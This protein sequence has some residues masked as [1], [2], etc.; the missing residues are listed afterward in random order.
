MI[1]NTIKL[2]QISDCHLFSN[3]NKSHKKI[4]PYQTLKKLLSYIQQHESNANAI[5]LTGD[6][7]QDESTTSYQLLNQLLTQT[8]PYPH[9]WLTGNHDLH[10]QTITQLIKKNIC[11]E[12]IDLNEHWQIITLNS[13]WLHHTQGLIGIRQLN[14]LSQ[15]LQDHTQKN[16]LIA[17]HHPICTTNS[18]WLDRHIIDDADLF[19]QTILPFQQQ[20]K[21]IIHGH[22]HQDQTW[23]INNIPIW[24]CPSSA[25]Q[26]AVASKDYQRSEERIGYR[27]L[28]LHPDG[29]ITTRVTRIDYLKELIQ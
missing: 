18:A 20:I 10:P 1:K 29:E 24:S 6:L 15:Q 22:I 27:V 11:P 13:R 5:L 23:Y 26:F 7:S 25:Y 16:T 8:L 4:N 9:Y 19:W 21:G 17:L 3:I 28:Q 12:Y 2:I 14:W